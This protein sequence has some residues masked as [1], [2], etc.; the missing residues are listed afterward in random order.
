MKSIWTAKY[1]NNEIRIENTWFNGERLF[2]NN[3]LQDEKSSLAS[4]TLTGQLT[5]T[6]NEKED[7]KVNLGGFVKIVCNLFIDHKKVAVTQEK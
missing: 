5:N 1:E 6:K 2:I 4:S 3:V 7:V